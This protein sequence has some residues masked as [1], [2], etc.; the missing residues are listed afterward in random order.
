MK[1]RDE[2]ATRFWLLAS[3]E[4]VRL[5]CE[6]E[7]FSVRRDAVVGTLKA[8]LIA[9]KGTLRR[10]FE[11]KAYRLGK[12]DDDIVALR[13][14]VVHTL[15]GEFQLVLVSPPRDRVIE[16]ERIEEILLSWLIDNMPNELDELSPHTYI[17]NV[18]S[19]IIAS[20]A[21]KENE[22]E[23]VGEATVEVTLEIDKE[24]DSSYADAYPFSFRVVLDKGLNVSR[25]EALEV[26]TS[27]FYQ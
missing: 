2:V 21:V 23:V 16:I 25:V 8:D 12:S 10:V 20:I 15:G 14:Y 7:G 18:S 27:D 13:N 4:E 24:P 19:A 26:D 6:E 9:E 22:L 5:R 1:V 11:F 17:D 3:I